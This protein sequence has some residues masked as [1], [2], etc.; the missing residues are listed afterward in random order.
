MDEQL[1]TQ[2]TQYRMTAETMGDAAREAMS[3]GDVGLARTAARQAAQ[4]ARVVMQLE[5]G[6]KMIEPESA[7]ETQ[8][9]GAGEKDKGNAQSSV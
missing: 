9:H 7:T 4:W 2:I 5:T 3:R 8:R 6:E 1:Q